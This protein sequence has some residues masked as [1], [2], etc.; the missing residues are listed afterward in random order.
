MNIANQ[1]QKDMELKFKAERLKII[2]KLKGLTQSEVIDKINLI[3][4]GNSK[5]PYERWESGEHEIKAIAIDTLAKVFEV[6]IGFFYYNKIQITMNSKLEVE[7]IIE[8]T[9]EK[10]NFNFI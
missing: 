1:K 6:P 3:T 4:G 2:R 5:R 8:E 9:N 10:V 7:I